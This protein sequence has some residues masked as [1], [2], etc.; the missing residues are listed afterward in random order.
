M[1]VSQQRVLPR[2]NVGKASLP[3]DVWPK[4]A[5]ETRHDAEGIGAT[6]HSSERKTG[7]PRRTVDIV[8]LLGRQLNDIE[9]KNA[10]PAVHIAGPMALPLPE[11]K[12]SIIGSRNAPPSGLAVARAMSKALSDADATIVSGLAAGVDAAAHREAI[13]AGGRTVAVIGT[14]LDRSYPAANAALQA[15]IMRDYLVISQFSTGRPVSRSNFVMRNRTMALLS[16][17]TVIT[18]ATG[19]SSG[20]RHQG[21]ESI[22]LG[23]PLFIHE[24]VMSE[25]SAVWAKDLLE[26]GA[27]LVDGPEPIIECIPPGIKMP[28]IFPVP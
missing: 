14:P 10:P 13:D 16:D 12:V 28:D 1:G 24:S 2:G 23:R 18:S 9:A 11:P 25:P 8:E 27:V 4:G 5:E 19:S 21:W 17:A 7:M 22:R 26:Y 15:E 20:T 6:V 3:A